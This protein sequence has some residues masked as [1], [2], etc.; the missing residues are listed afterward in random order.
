MC[1][2]DSI[3]P[4]ASIAK[5]RDLSWDLVDWPGR[6]SDRA[7]GIQAHPDMPAHRILRPPP[8]VECAKAILRRVDLPIELWR[9]IVDPS[10]AQPFARV[11]VGLAEGIESIDSFRIARAPDAEWADANGDPRLCDVHALIELLNEVIDVVATPIVAICPFLPTPVLDPRRLIGEVELTNDLYR[12][13]M[14]S[15]P[16]AAV[17]CSRLAIRVEEIVEV[18]AIDVVS[19][20]D[21]DDRRQ[22]GLARR[23]NTRIDPLLP[24]VTSDPI[25][26]RACDVIAR[27]AEC[28]RRATR[29]RD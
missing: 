13:S 22:Y 24:S 1:P 17:A 23:R 18:D 9:E 29:E 27:G 15:A 19:L 25:T 12:V 20:H 8:C 28:R 14:T 10:F 5:D 26:V 16:D 11:G 7:R 3:D 6:L 21:I 4:L 2:L